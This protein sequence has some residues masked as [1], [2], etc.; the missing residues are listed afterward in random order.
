M[1]T[2]YTARIY[3]GEDQSFK[4]FAI[5]CS[6][7]F[8]S[9]SHLWTDLHAYDVGHDSYCNKIQQAI[10]EIEK[11][12]QMPYEEIEEIIKTERSKQIEHFQKQ[13]TLKNNTRKRFEEMLEQAESWSPPTEKHHE[14][15]DFMINQLKSGIE[16]TTDKY[17]KRHL[18]ELMSKEETVEE[19]RHKMIQRRLEDIQ[20]TQD[21]LRDETKAIAERNQWIQ[22][23]R[24]SLKEGD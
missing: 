16:E 7:A 8:V 3:E 2:M 11:F 4:E 17:D 22:A 20:F 19:Y 10:A 24:R 14:F 18:D 5:E 12:T 13:I 21:R 15:K 1:P 9:H 23:L 6:R